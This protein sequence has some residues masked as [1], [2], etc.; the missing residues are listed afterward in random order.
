MLPFSCRDPSCVVLCAWWFGALLRERPWGSGGPSGGSAVLCDCTWPS[1]AL[2]WCCRKKKCPL[3]GVH[4]NSVCAS[5]VDV[6]CSP[7]CQCSISC[8]GERWSRASLCP[9]PP[10]HTVVSNAWC[11]EGTFSAFVD[12]CIV[13]VQR[14]VQ[15]HARI[16]VR[17]KTV[18]RVSHCTFGARGP[19]TNTTHLV[20]IGCVVGRS[21]AQVKMRLW[22]AAG[23]LQG[24]TVRPSAPRSPRA[25]GLRQRLLRRWQ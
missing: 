6:G 22:G 13:C 7:V 3:V 14:S 15:T 10:T 9:P 17:D 19:T 25:V 4:V 24:S 18:V 20:V 21:V 5:W 1:R 16:I 11:F 2:M 12:L 23:M 8:C